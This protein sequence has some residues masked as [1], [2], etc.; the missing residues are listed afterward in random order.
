MICGSYFILVEKPCMRRDW[1]RQFWSRMQRIVSIRK[2]VVG[3][4]VAD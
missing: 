2:V 4:D 1:P 3:S